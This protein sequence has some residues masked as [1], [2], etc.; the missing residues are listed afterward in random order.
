MRFNDPS[1]SFLVVPV[2][3]NFQWMRLTSVSAAA[4]VQQMQ[5][6]RPILDAN[7]VLDLVGRQRQR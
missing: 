1:P 3:R 4:Q 2:L 7:S 6:R 5:Q